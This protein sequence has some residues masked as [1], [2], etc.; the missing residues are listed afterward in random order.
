MGL[1]L[2]LAILFA[3]QMGDNIRAKAETFK[4]KTR[5]ICDQAIND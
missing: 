2:S 1:H 5:Q 4:Q 3:F